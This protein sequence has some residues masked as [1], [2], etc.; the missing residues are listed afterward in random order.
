MRII[1]TKVCHVGEASLLIR[2]LAEGR[3][4]RGAGKSDGVAPPAG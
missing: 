4:H 2:P 3:I 1:A